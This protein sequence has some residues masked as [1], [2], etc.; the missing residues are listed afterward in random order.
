MDF[1]TI[2]SPMIPRNWILRSA[3]F[4]AVIPCIP[5]AIY[6]QEQNSVQES[7]PS[8]SPVQSLGLTDT[9][10][11]EL[12]HAVRARDYV[13]AEKLLLSEINK[14]PQSP[15][16]AKLLAYVGSVYFLNA[17][18][19]NAA[20]AWKK[21]DA[22]LPLAPTLQFSLAMAYIR[23]S[24]PGWARPLLE[25]LAAGNPTEGLYPYWL[26]RL[27]YDGHDYP[28]AIK[29]FQHAIELSPRMARAYDNLGLCYYYQNENN[30]AIENY[31]KAIE[32]D[33]GAPFPSPWP[34]LNLA[35]TLQFLNKSG[36]A[37]NDLRE[38]LRIDQQFKQ[39]HLQLGLVLEQEG[40]LE[41]A[42][43]ELREAAR[44][45]ADFPEPHMAMARIL[46]RMGQEDAA[47]AEVQVYLKLHPPSTPKPASDK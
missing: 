36:E 18:Y 10:A 43:A 19:L 31:E 40:R 1:S 38:S 37:E 3:A 11:T 24:H 45:D 15:R 39:A 30:L 33:K 29:H 2:L 9:Q 41:E 22:I 7:V 27:A 12:Q 25:S 17:D 5:F 35:I 26:G 46:H 4:V 42:L 8:A 6:S 34:Y 32:L 13:T 28:G 23:I 16:A 44:I 47:Q 21:S 20:I 14:D